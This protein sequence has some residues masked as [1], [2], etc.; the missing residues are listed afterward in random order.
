TGSYCHDV[1]K[2]GW[3][4]RLSP[5]IAPPGDQYT[6]S[7][8]HYIIIS[9]SG[10]AVYVGE[11]GRHIRLSVSIPTPSKHRTIAKQQEIMV[12]SSRESD[13]V[14]NCWRGWHRDIGKGSIPVFPPVYYGA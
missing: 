3:H 14:C 6:V 4:I 11:S 2:S 7:S 5:V 1:C 13:D 8:L 9:A 12:V 10:D